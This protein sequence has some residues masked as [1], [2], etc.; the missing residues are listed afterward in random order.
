MNPPEHMKKKGPP[1]PSESL[2]HASGGVD[3]VPETL[4]G[5]ETSTRRSTHSAVS[6][7]CT[8]IAFISKH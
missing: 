6:P 2:V 8:T 7:N 1:I 4:C 5:E 3:A